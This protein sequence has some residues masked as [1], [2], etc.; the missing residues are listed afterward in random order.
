[1]S[2]E[3]VLKLRTKCCLANLA[4][5]CVKDEVVMWLANQETSL[6]IVLYKFSGNA[7]PDLH[8]IL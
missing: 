3:L 7:D 2:P 5:I 6:A 4:V 1:M 8:T